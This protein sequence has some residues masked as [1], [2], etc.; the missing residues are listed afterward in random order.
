[1]QLDGR[2]HMLLDALRAL[3][4]AIGLF[5]ASTLLSAIGS[6]L[7]SYGHRPSFEVSAIAALVSGAIAVLSLMR[8]CLG[9]ARETLLAVQTIEGEL[10]LMDLAPIDPQRPSARSRDKFPG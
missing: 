1:M 5:A 3:Y 4:T 6:V 10:Q 9:I 2:A 7:A 8:G